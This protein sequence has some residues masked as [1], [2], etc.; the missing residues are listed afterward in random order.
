MGNAITSQL[1]KVIFFGFSGL[2][3]VSFTLLTFLQGIILQLG[4]DLTGALI[5]YITSAISVSVAYL[6]YIRAKLAL[7]VVEYSELRN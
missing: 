6:I 1:F 3:L 2:L 4:G 7:R 5:Y